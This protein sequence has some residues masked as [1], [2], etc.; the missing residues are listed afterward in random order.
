M[1]LLFVVVC[2]V[3]CVMCVLCCVCVLP[4]V[5]HYKQVLCLTELCFV[6]VMAPL[7]CVL[8]AVYTAA[9]I[10]NS[11][12]IRNDCTMISKFMFV[13]ALFIH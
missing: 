5:H 2:V 13:Q 3:V 7:L 1:L 10:A 6:N 9:L 4:I 8:T 11:T 12:H